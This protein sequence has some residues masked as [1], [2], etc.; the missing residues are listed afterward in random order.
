MQIK[1]DFKDT[2][3]ALSGFKQNAVTSDLPDFGSAISAVKLQANSPR[4][5]KISL[6]EVLRTNEGFLSLQEYFLKSLNESPHNEDEGNT[7]LLPILAADEFAFSHLLSSIFD[8]LEEIYLLDTFDTIDPKCS[9]N[10][11]T[12]EFY[13]CILLWAAKEE[14]KLTHALYIHSQQFFEMIS[15]NQEIITSE[16]LLRFGRILGFREE[17]LLSSLEHIM[18]KTISVA[19]CDD[20]VTFY[21]YLFS[22]YDQAFEKY[23]KTEIS[24]TPNNEIAKENIED[25]KEHDKTE[26]PEMIGNKLAAPRVKGGCCA[27]QVCSIF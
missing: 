2:I 11:S 14:G 21:Y 18:G 23:A 13:L 16:R 1:T 15:A 8:N 20:F 12:K 3:L 25:T 24:S 9:G 22:Q 26:G 6:Y 5:K 27:A 19:N 17:V 7:K 10:I 4:D